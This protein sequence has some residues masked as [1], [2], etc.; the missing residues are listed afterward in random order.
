MSERLAGISNKA[1]S[2][3]AYHTPTKHLIRNTT[4][5]SIC[6]ASASFR[7]HREQGGEAEFAKC[8]W[9]LFGSIACRSPLVFVLAAV[10]WQATSVTFSESDCTI[11]L[12]TL[13]MSYTLLE[14]T[15]AAFYH[16]SLR[17]IN[18]SNAEQPV[19][20]YA[21]SSAASLNCTALTRLLFWRFRKSVTKYQNSP[22]PKVLYLSF[23]LLH[24][25]HFGR[26][27]QLT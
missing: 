18:A 16:L 9:C 21:S 6:Q 22:R 14:Y 8:F 4:S 23:S 17:T 15:A 1:T 11:R 24:C 3:V 5:G 20:T 12:C 25:Q 27:R 26:S 7:R 13:G 10:F 19:S 2:R